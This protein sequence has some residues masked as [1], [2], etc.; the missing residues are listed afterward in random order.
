MQPLRGE[1]S[2]YGEKK[3]TAR[4]VAATKRAVGSKTAEIVDQRVDS[5]KVAGAFAAT[6]E[7]IF[8]R[9]LGG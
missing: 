5:L 7:T 3:P 4:F 2:P 1:V 9:F 6:L 8:G